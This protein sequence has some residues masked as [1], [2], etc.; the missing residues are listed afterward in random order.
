MRFRL[1]DTKLKNFSGE[2][3]SQILFEIYFLEVNVV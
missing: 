3:Q 2:K 1:V